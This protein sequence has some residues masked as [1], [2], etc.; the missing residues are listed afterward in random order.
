MNS[1][2]SFIPTVDGN[3]H[4]TRSNSLS[5]SIRFDI[6]E[7]ISDELERVNTLDSDESERT[8]GEGTATNGVVS[9][10]ICQLFTFGRTEMIDG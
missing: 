3:T 5:E 8:N 4:R 9:N 10:G 2:P 7:M 1:I 6:T